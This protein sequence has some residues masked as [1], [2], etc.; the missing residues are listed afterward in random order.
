M[1][2]CYTDWGGHEILGIK[3]RNLVWTGLFYF[4]WRLGTR[5]LPDR[6]I[7][8]HPIAR[9]DFSPHPHSATISPSRQ[10]RLD[11]GEGAHRKHNVAARGF[12]LGELGEL[13]DRCQDVCRA[14]PCTT[15]AVVLHRL[16]GADT[17]FPRSNK[18]VVG[19]QHVSSAFRRESGLEKCLAC[20]TPNFDSSCIPTQLPRIPFPLLLRA[21]PACRSLAHSRSQR[22]TAPSSTMS[23][24]ACRSTLKSTAWRRKC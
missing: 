24:R 4:G 5:P 6:Y 20:T 15:R 2:L 8:T 22:S 11:L 10:S 17:A 19:V 16:T 21:T 14:V 13:G 9:L 1:Q 12:E 3:W 18:I 23:S 7:S